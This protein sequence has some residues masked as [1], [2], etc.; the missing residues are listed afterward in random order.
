MHAHPDALA[1][2]AARVTTIIQTDGAITLAIL[3]DEPDTSRRY[4]QALLEHLDTTR[5]TL[6]LQDNRR[7]LRGRP[8]TKR[9]HAPSMR[10]LLRWWTS[11][12]DA[13]VVW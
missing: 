7:V 2:I 12:A 8:A 10:I 5:V 9:E 3:R 13:D 1:R 11:V 6:R 4:A